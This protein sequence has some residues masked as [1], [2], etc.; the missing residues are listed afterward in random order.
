MEIKILIWG[1]IAS[2]GLVFSFKRMSK[3]QNRMLE[4]EDE[5]SRGAGFLVQ[6]RQDRG[7]QKMEKEER[8]LFLFQSQEFAKL[9]IPDSR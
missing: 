2:P 4:E 1:K 6:K 3:T 9:K 8:S 7:T 5:Y